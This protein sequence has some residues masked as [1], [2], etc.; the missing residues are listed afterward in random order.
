[1]SGISHATIGALLHA[2]SQID[3]ANTELTKAQTRIKTATDE[4]KKACW[5]PKQYREMKSR[6]ITWEP[7]GG[8][9]LCDRSEVVAEEFC[10]I[11]GKNMTFLHKPT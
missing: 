10:V 4:L 1:V 2:R 11:C 5:H 6:T 7:V 8:H 3:E 9:G